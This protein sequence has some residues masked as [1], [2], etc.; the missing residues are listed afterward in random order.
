[1]GMRRSLEAPS[2]T[3]T[4]SGTVLSIQVCVYSMLHNRNACTDL[5]TANGLTLYCGKSGKA[6]ACSYTMQGTHSPQHPHPGPLRLRP[7]TEAILYAA[8]FSCH[9]PHRHHPQRARC[10]HCHC[11]SE[12]VSTACHPGRLSASSETHGNQLWG[13]WPR[14]VAHCHM[15]PAPHLHRKALVRTLLRYYHGRGQMHCAGA[16][17]LYHHPHSGPAHSHE[18]VVFLHASAH[19][20]DSVHV[21]QAIE[22]HT[23]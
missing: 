4:A 7:A 3:S 17:A 10:D 20:S 15:H 6:A 23:K 1:M 16:Y 12:V 21:V 18:E 14:H 5:E 9:H 2:A 19:H 8:R 13:Y 11:G 22:Q